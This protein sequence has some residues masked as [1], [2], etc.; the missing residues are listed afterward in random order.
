MYILA[1][2]IW[3]AIPA[4]VMGGWIV[5]VALV[6]PFF[7]YPAHYLVFAIA[8]GGVFLGGAIVVWLYTRKR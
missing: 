1:G 4:I 8:G 3:R 5:L 2:G 7:G 6:A